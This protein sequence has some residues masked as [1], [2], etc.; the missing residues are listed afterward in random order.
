MESDTLNEFVCLLL[1]VLDEDAAHIRQTLRQL[2]ALRAAV[3]K[4]DDAE[5]KSLL[6]AVD[7]ETHR[8]RD[9]DCRRKRICDA[10]AELT[11]RPADTVSLSRLC[12]IAGE[13]LAAEIRSRQDELKELVQTLRMEH[14]CTMILLR[15]CSR[16]NA[17]LLDGILGRDRRTVTYNA[18]GSETWRPRNDIVD[19][20][21]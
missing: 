2:N 16:L 1:D 20:R 7:A 17:M 10:I 15:E 21:L 12:Q 4:R 11:G 18:R 14:T 13:P 6:E 9:A 3:I 5:L 19:M 8:R